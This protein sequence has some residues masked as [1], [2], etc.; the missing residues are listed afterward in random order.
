MEKL[1]DRKGFYLSPKLNETTNLLLAAMPAIHCL[2]KNHMCRDSLCRQEN[3]NTVRK[4]QLSFSGFYCGPQLKQ[5]GILKY[6][7][8]QKTFW[9]S[10]VFAN[11][12]ILRS[13][14]ALIWG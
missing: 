11:S 1:W 6:V 3:L 9:G 5:K 13:S 2:G 10:A 4:S 7:K 8:P 14:V 12:G